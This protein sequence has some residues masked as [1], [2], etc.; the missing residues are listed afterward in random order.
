MNLNE[1]V[2][3]C[4]FTQKQ[5]VERLK[6]FNCYK[7]QQQIS[8]WCRGIRSPDI[9]SVYYLSKILNVSTDNIISC[10]IR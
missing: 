10:F 4:G 6:K 7:Y 5:L 8:E 3:S 2:R 9:E 1:L